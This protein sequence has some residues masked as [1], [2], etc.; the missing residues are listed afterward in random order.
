M[1]APD[2]KAVNEA[3]ERLQL[4]VNELRQKCKSSGVDCETCDKHQQAHD[5][6]R[7]EL[8]KLRQRCEELESLAKRVAGAPVGPDPGASLAVVSRA[9]QGINRWK[10]G[11]PFGTHATDGFLLD[12][13]QALI[14]GLEK[15]RATS[16]QIEPIG[17]GY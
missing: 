4:G 2:H 8:K 9:Q 16:A 6:I 11:E 15:Q 7:A 3:L 10:H 1:T 12:D 14:R 5:T 17:G 13:L